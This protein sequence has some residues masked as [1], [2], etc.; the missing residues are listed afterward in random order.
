MDENY[1]RVPP[2]ALHRPGA[3]PTGR[4][5]RGGGI[6]PGQDGTPDGVPS[7]G[8]RRPSGANGSRTALERK[9][10]TGLVQRPASRHFERR[11]S[12]SSPAC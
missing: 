11:T 1:W 6:Q 10:S 8:I 4:V 2:H 3:D 7:G 9:D 5:S 12:R